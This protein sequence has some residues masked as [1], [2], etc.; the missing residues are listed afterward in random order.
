M[1]PC[2]VSPSWI[3]CPM[4]ATCPTTPHDKYQSRTVYPITD[5]PC[6]PTEEDQATTSP[7][8]SHSNF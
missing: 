4:M 6:L 8:T 1:G 7:T 5:E 3:S 2:F